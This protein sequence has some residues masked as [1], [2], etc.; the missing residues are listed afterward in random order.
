MKHLIAS[1]LASLTLAACGGGGGGADEDAPVPSAPVVPEGAIRVYL[2]AGQSN[3]LGSDA[4]IDPTTGTADLVDM[5]QQIEA[6]RSTLFTMSTRFLRYDWGDVRGHV[7]YRWG[8]LTI[9]GEAVKVHGPEVGFAREM[10]GNIAIIKYADNYTATENGRSPWVKPGS[11]WNA[12]HAFVEQQLASLGRPY[13]VAGFVWFQGIDDGLLHRGQDRY[14]ADL[15]QI[16]ADLRAKYGNVPFV[17]ARSVDSQIAG[18]Y[19]MAPIRAAQ[20]AVGA[21]PGNA[22][23]TVDDLP[24]VAT[25]HLTAAGQLEVGRRF[26]KA[27]KGE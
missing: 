6:D 3:M 15:E 23:I 25:H 5:G 4:L 26:A 10:G 9:N 20:E 2:F 8:E 14:Q 12:W 7:G 24:L 17:L 16:A 27:M 22:L 13:V 21:Q 11:R 19:Y 1:I 18:S